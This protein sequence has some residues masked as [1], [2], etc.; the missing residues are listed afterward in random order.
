MGKVITS[1]SQ[2]WASIE[3]GSAD[4]GDVRRTSRL[5][6]VGA[7]AC[8]QP[9]GKVAAVFESDRDREGAYDF[10]E[11]EHVDA[12]EI[13]TAMAAATAKRSV[14]LEFVLVALDGTS[15]SVTDWTKDRDFGRIGSD[16]NGARGLKVIDAL[17]VDPEGTPVGLLALTFWTRSVDQPLPKKGHARQARPVEEKETQRWI[18]TVNCACTALDDK[19]VRGWFQLDREGDGRDLLLA[20]EGTEHWWTVRGNRDRSIELLEGDVGKLRDE[21]SRQTVTTT[22]SLHVK[23]RP[24][25]G[26]RA[27]VAHMVV[28]VARVTLRLRDQKTRRITPMQINAVWA[29]EEGTTPVSED[30]I[31]W[32]LYTNHAVDTEEDALLVIYG[33]SQRWRVEDF[34]RTW[35]RGD[36]DV[37]STQ[38]RSADAVHR[39]ATILAAVAAR[40]ERLKHLA[41]NKPTAPASVDLDGLE[42]RALMLLKFGSELAHAA[43]TLGQVVMWL[44]EIGGFTNRY[45]DRLPGATVLGRALD[46]VRLAARVLDL[47]ERAQK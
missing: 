25:G 26:R 10:L 23:A 15:I 21:L 1:E 5:V 19:H 14:G 31:D 36:C 11:S 38:L 42:L 47:K 35:K 40:I 22:Y 30:P 24:G 2:Q 44:A 45:S 13:A 41:R 37:E 33:Y 43:P 28:R 3:F 39:W 27:R 12:S 9:S 34:H 17:A 6:A 8:E 20:L 4:L 18:D 7:A 32:L 46:R 29:R 16:D